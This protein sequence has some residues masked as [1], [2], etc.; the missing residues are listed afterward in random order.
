MYTPDSTDHQPNTLCCICCTPQHPLTINPTHSVVFAVHPSIHWPS[1]QHSLL[2]LLYTPASTDHQPNTLL[3]LL[4]TSASTD[5]QPNTLCC[6]CCTPQHPLTINPTLSV[7]F[8][9]HPSI[10]WPS[11][12]HSV[13]F[14]FHLSI[15]WPSTQ[16]SVV[17]A[18]HPST[19]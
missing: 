9:V 10:H 17:F 4:F 7:V 14:A 3:Y 16:H 13:V 8:A 11:T 12:Q 2:Y 6:I 18:V 5:H 19:H 15:H 1:T